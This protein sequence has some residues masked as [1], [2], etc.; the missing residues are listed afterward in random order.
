MTD[1]AGPFLRWIGGKQQIVDKL[2]GLLPNN[3]GS[4][5]YY[6]PFL[7]AGS[8][9]FR[10]EP[11][12]AHL[13][14]LN[15]H[16]VHCYSY[17]RRYPQAVARHLGGHL[18]QNSEGYYYSQR[19]VYNS[20]RASAAQA[21]RFIYLNK[22]CFNGIFRVNTRGEFNVPYGHKDPPAIPLLSDLLLVSKALQSASI[23]HC[24]YEKALAPAAKGSFVYL[25]PPYP[26]L[27][28]TSYFTHYTADRFG[29]TDQ[30]K[31]AVEVRRIHDAGALFMMTNAD[32]EL[33]R[34]LY[35]GFHLRALPVVRY[36]TC[37]KKRHKVSELVITNYELPGFLG[38][39]D[40]R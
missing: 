8:L 24:S 36:V 33:V 13:S 11:A 5:R 16:L 10:L 38:G 17:V 32:T 9:F 30:E 14:D 25:D 2:T 37:K 40:W 23:T 7:G 4:L 21:A 39:E 15:P 19:A 28:G 27:N 3:V 26:P 29:V 1:T 31:L 6:E 18:A 20:A 34:R 12:E 22:S 35:E